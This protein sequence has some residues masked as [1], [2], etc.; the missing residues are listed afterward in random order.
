MDKYKYAWLFELI[1]CTFALAIIRY[2][3]G[4][5]TLDSYLPHGSDILVAYFIISA[6]TSLAFEYLEFN[7]ENPTRWN[8]LT[9]FVQTEHH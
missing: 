7:K 5:F 6:I 1:R 9:P 2:Y 8:S 3:G 4:W